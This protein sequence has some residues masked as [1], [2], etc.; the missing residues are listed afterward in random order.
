MR[1]KFE[2]AA[3]IRE[4]GQ[5]LMRPFIVLDFGAYEFGYFRRGW[6]LSKQHD[7]SSFVIAIFGVQDP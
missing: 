6:S 5:D 2:L 4:R 3:A 1:K 7:N